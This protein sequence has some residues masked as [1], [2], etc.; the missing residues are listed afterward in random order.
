MCGEKL[1]QIGTLT[2]P[3]RNKIASGS[4][5]I[6]SF[7]IGSA[8]TYYLYRGSQLSKT[9]SDSRIRVWIDSVPGPRFIRDTFII[10]Y[11]RWWV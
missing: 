5:Q 2:G 10:K 3:L 11:E 9:K 6:I 8:M 7:S 1:G 4:L